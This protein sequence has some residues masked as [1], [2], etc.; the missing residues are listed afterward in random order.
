MDPSI[1]IP[2]ALNTL[3]NFLLYRLR[4]DNF[5]QKFL[6]R[7]AQTEYCEFWQRI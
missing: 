1:L 3:K 2:N 5:F 6:R 7:F 4:N